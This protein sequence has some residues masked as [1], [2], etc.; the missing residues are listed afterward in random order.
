MPTAGGRH[1]LI[2]CCEVD[3]S[4]TLLALSDEEFI[5]DVCQRF[6]RPIGRFSN[7]SARRSHPL[8]LSQAESPTA[9]RVA[10]VGAA[11][12]TVHPNGAQGLNLGLRD[13]AA[14]CNIVGN[15][16]GNVTMP[17]EESRRE[18]TKENRLNRLGSKEQLAAFAANRAQD[19]RRVIRFTDGM[20]RGFASK[21]PGAQFIRRSTMLLTKLV[22][23][24]QRHIIYEGAGHDRYVGFPFKEGYPE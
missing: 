21:F 15:V 3:E 7:L 13:V 11:A 8:V 14:L 16:V 2:R 4:E 23:A 12:V 22:P 5:E 10:L 19:H 20:A 24:L 9:E 18:N 6:A 17:N 1:V